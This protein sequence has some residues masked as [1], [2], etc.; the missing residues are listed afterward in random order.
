MSK[1]GSVLLNVPFIRNT[2]EWAANR[3][4]AAVGAEL[5]RYGLRYDDLINEKDE[6]VQQALANLTPLEA[7]LRHKRIKR[8]IDLDLKKTYL[9]EELQAKEDIWNPYVRDR[10]KQIKAERLERQT[11]D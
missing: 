7:E 1:I 4:K 6:D 9:P 3:Y 10:V 2:V 11:Y 8:A 5:R